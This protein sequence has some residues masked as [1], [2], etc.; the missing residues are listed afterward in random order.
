MEDVCAGARA[1]ASTPEHAYNEIVVVPQLALVYVVVRKSACTT[2]RLALLKFFNATMY[3][4]EGL[5]AT[6]ACKTMVDNRCSTSCLTPEII[7]E[8][9]Y[10][11]FSFVRDPVERFYSSL[12]EA[13]RMNHV[14]AYTRQAAK[15]ILASMSSRECGYD[16]HLES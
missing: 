10:F 1:N 4:C 13:A 6:S 16:H 7:R 5:N 15:D 11:V 3:K 9:K 14:L 12:Y 2:I 8:K